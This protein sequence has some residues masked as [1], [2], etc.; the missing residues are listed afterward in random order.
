MA[1][2][3]RAQNISDVTHGNTSD[4]VAA[5]EV[6]GDTNGSDGSNTV[7]SRDLRATKK[8]KKTASKS[9]H[10]DRY[11][12]V[13]QLG[14]GG[15]GVVEKAI[16]RQLQRPVAIK[17]I[18][19]NKTIAQE[20]RDRFMHEAKITSQLQHPGIVP[21]H[22]LEDGQATGDVFY[23][24]KLLSGKPLRQLIR[25]THEAY[26]QSRRQTKN[27][28]HDRLIPLLERFVDVCDAIAYAHQQS[29]L[30]R[31]LKPDN[32]MIGGFGETI[33]VDW[34]LA[35]RLVDGPQSEEDATL[36]YKLEQVA[37]LVQ[38]EISFSDQTADGSVIGTP[39]YMSPEQANG[40]ITGLTSATDIYSLG[41]ML[42]EIL[43]GEHPHSGLDVKT[44]LTRVREGTYTAANEAKREVPRAL[45][46]IC[47]RAMSM[48]PTDRYACADELANDVRNYIAGE[49][50]SVD[51]EPLLERVARWCKKN[52]TLTFAF[53]GLGISI[54]IG[55]LVSGFF[56]HQA[57]EAEKKAHQATQAAHRETILRLQHSRDAADTWLIE[58]SSSLQF[59]PGLQSI[60]DDLI[61]QAIVHYAELLDWEKKWGNGNSKEHG[62]E[63][64]QPV[65]AMHQSL[66]KSVKVQLN[67]EE[68]KVH[69]RLG[70]LFRLK[71]DK[72]QASQHYVLAEQLVKQSKT[73]AGNEQENELSLQH[74]NVIVGKT[75][76]ANETESEVQQSTKWLNDRIK[77]SGIRSD[78]PAKEE[79]A[80]FKYDLVSSRSRMA[81]AQ[82]R[83]L[84][85][86]DAQQSIAHGQSAMEWARWLVLS[87]G[88]LADCRLFETAT[89]QY[90]DQCELAQQYQSAASAW[91][92][93]VEQMTVWTSESKDR[94]DQMQSLAYARFQWANAISKTAN[95]DRTVIE[96][97]QKLY[98]QSIAEFKNAWALSDADGFYQRNLASAENNLGNLLADGDKAQQESACDHLSNSL[99]IRKGLI[100]QQPSVDEIRLYCHSISR[101]VQ[102]ENQLQHPVELSLLNE[103]DTCFQLVRDHGRLSAQ[104]R[105]SWATVLR[106]RANVV[107]ANGEEDKAMI[108]RANAKQ[109]APK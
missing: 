78:T 81:L 60:R 92:I 30:H 10:P 3:Q 70:D 79:I 99:A 6:T 28:L 40:D 11:Q 38:G 91:Q 1:N 20:V 29:I 14:R 62:Y 68:I 42:Y 9:K 86:T 77:D 84:A 37:E 76:L 46:A 102:L 32:V 75:L 106:L 98:R 59:H 67:L 52:Q 72:D 58:L 2:T 80:K 82:S 26:N 64:T 109:L 63:E 27:E 101:L 31:D 66:P 85:E 21:V 61:D 103:A 55:S 50:V 47:D 19:S 88:S 24:M 69:L 22:E 45:S 33:V 104:D 43:V 4:M 34:G 95:G 17:R 39:A 65:S 16:D 15:W 105:N 54:L 13:S 35:K 23:V 97:A 94:I 90:A 57:H 83:R 12:T 41:V 56:I 96:D 44:V 48:K 107:E 8:R 51:R 18:A 74:A 73:I 93:L 5:S 7:S 87:R 36:D 49:P 100:R 89:M 108:D 71:Q 25:D 53:T